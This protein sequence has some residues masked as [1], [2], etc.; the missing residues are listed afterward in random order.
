MRLISIYRGSSERLRAVV[1]TMSATILS[2]L[3]IAIDFSHRTTQSSMAV[4]IIGGLL[5]STTLTLFVVPMVFHR[6][7]GRRHG[8]A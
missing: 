2:M 5:V 3:P 8:H 1:I 6:Y 4:A 7:L